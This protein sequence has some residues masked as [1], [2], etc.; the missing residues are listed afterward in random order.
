MNKQA[1]QQKTLYCA[2]SLALCVIVTGCANNGGITPQATMQ[3]ANHLDAGNA[4]RQV[5]AKANW[6]EVSWWEKFADPQ[7]NHLITTAIQD[8]PTMAIAAARVRQ[9]QGLA[10]AAHGG[11]LPQVNLDANINRTHWSENGYYGGGTFAGTNSWNNT[12]TLSLSYELDLWGRDRDTSQRALDQLYAVAADAR[13]AQLELESNIVRTYIQLALQYGLQDNTQEMLA[14]QQQMLQLA[15]RR[16]AGGLG[17]QLE[18]SSAEVVLPETRRQLETLSGNIALLH[19]QLAALMGKGPGAGET[20]TRPTLALNPEILQTGLLPSALP[21]DLI[22]HRPDITAARWRVEAAAK[23]FAVAKTAFYPNINLLANIGPAAAG[24]NMLSFLALNN[25]TS[26]FGPAISLPIFE[27]GRL[28]G[29]LG[30]AAANYDGEV[31]RYNQLL[32]TALQNIADQVT[33][34]HSLQRQQTEATLSITTAQK[35]VAIATRA[36]QRGL[37]NYLNVLTAQ[38]QLL[39]QQQIVQ[40]LHAQQL[41]TYATL[42]AALGGGLE[43]T[44]PS[45]T[46]NTGIGAAQ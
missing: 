35:N 42:I 13:A 6:P 40:Q 3:S 28:R 38:S 20:I 12:A 39:N 19:N 1:M 4:I 10:V 32:I 33:N 24:G 21:A 11:E 31:E 26:A 7:L 36:Y 8:N 15:Q 14:R 34:L 27:G 45:A 23:G 44:P 9:A 18:V 29:E 43:D 2:L 46:D 41:S 5:A 17:T 16:Y 25:F 22:G 37:T 30:A